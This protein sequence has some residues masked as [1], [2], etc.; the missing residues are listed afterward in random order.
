MKYLSIII[1][2]GLTETKKKMK[3]SFILIIVHSSYMDVMQL[4]KEFHS[5]YDDYL[6][7]CKSQES[8]F[9]QA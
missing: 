1:L 7:V 4:F 5:I 6:C 2:F 9:N 8:K 3:T